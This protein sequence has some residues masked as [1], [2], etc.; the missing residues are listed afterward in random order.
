[1]AAG[2]DGR[3]KVNHLPYLLDIGVWKVKESLFCP[4]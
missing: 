1:M 4:E 2:Q 3:M